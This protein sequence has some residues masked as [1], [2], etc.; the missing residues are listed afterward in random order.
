MQY[1]STQLRMRRGIHREVAELGRRAFLADTLAP[2]HGASPDFVICYAWTGTP[3]TTREFTHLPTSRPMA[4]KTQTPR[5]KFRTPVSVS[6]T[7]RVD[8]LDLCDECE[9]HFNLLANFDCPK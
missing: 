1:S 3:A 2:Q 7:G 4:Q 9:K 6:T 5:A 8:A